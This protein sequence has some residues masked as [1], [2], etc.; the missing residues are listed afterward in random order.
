[1]ITS[2]ITR[3]ITSRIASAIAGAR[4]GGGAWSPLTLFSGSEEGGYYDPSDLSTLWQD[5]AGTVPVTTDGQTVNRIDDLSGNG[6][7]LRS[8]TAGG[9]GSGVVYKGAGYLEATNDINDNEI[10]LGSGSS[11]SYIAMA[12]PMTI[13]CGVRGSTSGG[14]GS[15]EVIAVRGSDS[16]PST[17]MMRMARRGDVS[18]SD[19]RIRGSAAVPSVAQITAV[20]STNDMP[21]SSNLTIRAE[22][23]SEAMEGYVGGVLGPS[24]S[25]SWTT[26]SVTGSQV[27][28]GAMGDEARFYGGVV[29]NRLLTASEVE[30]M[31]AWL[32]ARMA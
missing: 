6:L 11:G 4:V 7:H 24:A 18:R 25:H 30:L 28:L 23:T 22:F 20:G 15:Y 10:R 1:M 13:F 14:A 2:P 12:V 3:P 19:M 32:N 27:V 17:N 31:E 5:A 21:S 16:S 8:D 9:V 26:Q 29:I